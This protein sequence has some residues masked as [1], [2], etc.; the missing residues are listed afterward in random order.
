MKNLL[1]VALVV[2]FFAAFTSCKKDY[3]CS[4]TIAGVTTD[5][6]IN[7][8]KKSDAETACDGLNVAAA[9]AG[10]SCTLN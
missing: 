1:A 2:F 9:L 10:G 5:T 3:V 7:D 4:C 8:S 6:P